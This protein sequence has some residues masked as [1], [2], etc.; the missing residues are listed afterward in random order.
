MSIGFLFKTANTKNC[1][2]TQHL[3]NQSKSVD[4][5]EITY[6]KDYVLVVY[7][8]ICFQAGQYVLSVIAARTD[9][10]A[11]FNLEELEG[12]MNSTSFVNFFHPENPESQSSQNNIQPKVIISPHQASSLHAV[13][14]HKDRDDALSCLAGKDDEEY[15]SDTVERNFKQAQ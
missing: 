12:D 2:R 5:F 9:L 14:S 13:I 11:E 6:N 7:Q 3:A 4:S 10:D 15:S 1:L 8:D